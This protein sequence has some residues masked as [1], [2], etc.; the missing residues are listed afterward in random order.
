M[1]VTNVLDAAE[2]VDFLRPAL[3]HRIKDRLAEEVKPLVNKIYEEEIAK[4]AVDI[5]NFVSVDRNGP[6]I[7]ITIHK[8]EPK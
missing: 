5:V 6:D 3:V 2:F 7:R 4:Y 1:N 8:L